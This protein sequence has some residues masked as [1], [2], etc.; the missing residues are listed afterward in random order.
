MSLI[1]W[2]VVWDPQTGRSIK[3]TFEGDENSVRGTYLALEL[4]KVHGLHMTN[5]GPLWTLTWLSAAPIDGTPEV[6]VDQW[7]WETDMIQEEI[8][9]NPKVAAA[10]AAD[11]DP[12]NTGT[13]DDKLAKWKVDITNQLTNNLGGPTL[14][15]ATNF[16]GKK[17]E[18]YVNMLRGGVAHEIKRPTLTRVRSFSSAYAPRQIV[19]GVENIY[20]TDAL[21]R[22]FGIPADIA[23]TMP[24]MT[25]ITPPSFTAWAWKERKINSTTVRNKGRTQEEREWVFAAW[26]TLPY[27]LIA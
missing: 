22:T 18:L 20:T 7:D 6:P 1:A 15:T 26:V 11:L 23:A 4:Q 9:M 24:D 5:D 8:W 3:Q 17:L 21:I 16:T 10:A 2:D 19:N 14:P 25:G 13:D 27:N 12:K